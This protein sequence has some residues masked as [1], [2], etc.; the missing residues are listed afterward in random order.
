MRHISAR[1]TVAVST[2]GFML[3]SRRTFLCSVM[4]ASSRAFLAKAEDRNP[5]IDSH[6]HVWTHN[7]RFPFAAGANVPPNIDASVETLLQRMQDNHVARTVLIQ[8]IH[9]KWDN[10]YLVDC[11][12]RFPNKFAGVCR[13]DPE[14]PDAPDKLTYWTEQGCRGV[15]LSPS[16]DASGDWIR[17]PLMPAL[18]KRCESLRIPMTLLIP[19]SRIPDIQPMMDRHPELTVVID[20][21]A[22]C[23]IDD[24]GARAKLLALSRYPRVFVKITHLWSLSR[25]T[26]PFA[27]TYDLV[28]R[29][30]DAFGAHRI[31]GGTDWPIKP[32]LASYAKRLALYRHELPFLNAEEREDI[33]SGT[34]QRVWPFNL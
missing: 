10:R 28:A 34:V 9:Y 20:H 23:P 29:V 14:S 31:M 12:Q 18:W 19:V 7:R 33:L 27:D 8:V 25:Q 17:G 1:S 13:V 3:W 6:V 21:M 26:Y 16:A 24:A 30:R 15:R 22:D 4:A 11:L 2:E 32:E 5:T